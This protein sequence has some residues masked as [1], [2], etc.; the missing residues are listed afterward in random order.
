MLHKIDS[1]F[2]F[3]AFGLNVRLVNEED[4]DF[5]LSLRTNTELSKYIHQTEN[6]RQKQLEWFREYK[7]REAEGRDYYF[8][9]FK[10]DKPIG[11]NRI[12][13]IY[14]YYG[15]PGSWLCSPDNDPIDSMSTY[16]CAREIYYNVLMLDLLVYDVRKAN[17]QVWKMHKM[18]GA[19]LIGE[20]EIYYYFAMS[21]D[22]Y[23]KKKDFVLKM[24]GITE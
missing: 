17:K 13:N 4:T 3:E 8:I 22:N 9:Y 23:M 24:L 15:T 16:F 19:Q 18:L 11:V 12:Y 20:S 6:D 14:E 5:I 10:N 21:K 7:K 1:D 2:S